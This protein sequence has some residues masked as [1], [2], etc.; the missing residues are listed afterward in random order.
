MNAFTY[1]QSTE[2]QFGR[3]RVVEVGA[4]VARYGKRCLVVTM[5]NSDYMAPLIDRIRASLTAAG[6][7]MA[8]FDG[9]VP[10]PTTN[11]VTAGADMAKAFGADVVLGVGGGSSMDTAKAIAVEAT[12]P[13][14]CWD[15][16]FFKTP[17]TTAT[18]PMIAVS[19]TSGTGSQVTQVAVV[20]ET[21]TQTKSALYN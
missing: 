17:P 2:I 19:T 12:H 4:A 10:N 11:C 1:F 21:A 15:Y 14:T 16:L 20:T 3:G 18:L 13:G 9:V 5:P 6:V 8:H 7:E